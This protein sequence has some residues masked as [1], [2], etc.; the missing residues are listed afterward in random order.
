MKKTKLLFLLVTLLFTSLMCMPIV[1]AE[2]C[3]ELDK[4]AC[5]AQKGCY[6]EDETNICAKSLTYVQCGDA[7]DIPSD[8]P[9]II[10]LVIKFFK[11]A[12]PI[13]LII[14]SMITLAKTMA[15]GKE[16][17]MNKAKS[18]LIRRMI[19]A[20]LTFFVISIVQLVLSVVADDAEESE[21][22]GSCLN[23]FIN[24]DCQNTKYYK[25]YNGTVSICY[26]ENGEQFNCPNGDSN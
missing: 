25:E 10:S 23:C 3:S 26:K 17:E 5:G 8:A 13:A 14:S 11:Y 12:A 21:N 20:V 2:N 22:I 16:D 7:Y 9:R 4:T 1:S 15:V 24:N 19:A 18:S 6:Y